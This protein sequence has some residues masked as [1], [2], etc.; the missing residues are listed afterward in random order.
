MISKK[1]K[2]YTPNLFIEYLQTLRGEIDC[3]E[4][5]NSLIP[6]A[7]EDPKHVKNLAEAAIL[8]FHSS[9]CSDETLLFMEL[10]ARCNFA[11]GDLKETIEAVTCI[12]NFKNVSTENIALDLAQD[13][14]DGADSF[15]VSFDQIT[16]V[17]KQI[18]FVFRKY[19]KYDV[20]INIY[21]NAASMYSGHN[22][23]QS[24]YRCIHDAENLSLEINS[25]SLL[26]KC[27][28]IAMT[29]ACE[30]PDFEWAV[31]AGLDSLRLYTLSN[32]LPP[33]Y[34]HSNLALAYMNIG[35]LD[36]AIGC[37]NK[38]L[39]YSDIDNEVLA[40]VLINLSTCLRKKGDIEEAVKLIERIEKIEGLD[41]YNE[42]QLEIM[43]SASKTY[44]SRSK[45]DK[46]PQRL[47]KAAYHLQK[48]L[49]RTLRL[50]FRRGIRERYIKRFEEIMRA[51]PN[52]GDAKDVLH[53]MV[54][55]HGNS[56]GD[57]LAILQWLEELR[58]D[59]TIRADILQDLSTNL[60]NIRRAGA[61]HLFGFSEKYDD[62]WEVMQYGKYWD[63]LSQL[64]LKINKPELSF[65]L[66]TANI[67]NIT[68]LC[69][70]RMEEGHC[71]VFITY[72]GENPLLWYFIRGKYKKIMLPIKDVLAWH[73]ALMLYSDNSINRS[74]F[75]QSLSAF[76][77]SIS[78]LLEMVFI[79]IA[80]NDCISIR[81]ITDSFAD[82]PLIVS[83]LNNSTLSKKMI[84][85]DF[86]I[87]SVPALFETY[88]DSTQF[89]SISSII[90]TNCD[91]LLPPYEASLLSQTSHIP[92]S[93]VIVSN[94]RRELNTL[95][96][97]SNI[98]SI[99]THGNPLGL[100]SDAYFAKLGNSNERHII[101]VENLQIYAPDLKLRLVLLNACFSG[102][103]SMRNFQKRFITNDSVVLAN[104][105]LLNRKAISLSSLWKISDTASY[106]LTHYIGEGINNDLNE[107]QALAS[108]IAKLH[109]TDL[110]TVLKI[111]TTSLPEDVSTKACERLKSAPQNGMFSSPYFF[112][113]L[114]IHGLL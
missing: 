104:L 48:I 1:W 107:S 37:F 77:E 82:L 74:E 42:L 96:G 114:M 30:E 94:E 34:L 20:I 86:H 16:N 40:N 9:D 14:I 53:A 66:K 84:N 103:R 44:I 112:G 11:L 98:L 49:S 18:E 81:Y 10:L 113:G 15:G 106:V 79:D 45:N 46:L 8:H 95:I 109:L 41:E 105:F 78:P 3:F 19:E 73:K 25:V 85:G 64:C 61:P 67:E 35:K 80:D 93:K 99:S 13:I 76:I 101:S 55:T 2:S 63:E 89:H 57:W 29:V 60:E 24:A 52:D 32:D 71:L 68:E 39:E 31:N 87:R 54:T 23:H 65:P 69:F 38:T 7:K 51:L 102:S 27:K 62:P 47:K 92:Q 6:L 108:A 59:T 5:Y 33:P 22:A 100:Y 70:R 50:H 12:T 91:L 17:Y 88:R 43:L 72:A 97:D 26:A 4:L 36:L 83:A 111:L 56:M 28:Y 90:S 21:L 75:T 58:T 110:N